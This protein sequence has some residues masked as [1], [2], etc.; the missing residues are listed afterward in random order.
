M[1]QD[2]QHAPL[3]AGGRPGDESKPGDVQASERAD[4]D[5]SG[6]RW[7]PECK[8]VLRLAVPVSLS[9]VVSFVAYLITTAQVGRLGTLELSAITLARSVY[10]ITGMSLVVGMASAVETF[11]GQAYG[12]AHYPV[13]GLVLQRAVTLCLLTCLLPLGLWLRGDW[14]MGQLMGQRP[15]VVPLAAS[16]LRLLGPALVM[17]AVSCCIKNYLS[18]QGVVTPLTV[19]AS[20][21]TLATAALNHVFMFSLGLGMQGAAVAYNLL[22]ALELLLLIGTMAWLHM[23]GQAPGCRT[24]CGFSVQ[25][26]RGWGKY[27]RIALPSGAAICLDWWTYEAVILMAGLLP[28]AKV[29]LGTMGLAFDTH[30][31][32][33]MVVGGFSTAAST[34]VSNELG[35]GRGRW[36][37][38]AALVALGL[39]M[40]APLGISGG[41]LATP[42]QWAALFTKDD[43]IIGL[44]ASLMPVL[45]L[46]NLADSVV[47]VL[48][49]VLRGSGRQELAFKVNLAAFWFL[50]LPL[51][52]RLA[53]HHHLGAL[54]LW[55]AMGLASAL[56]AVILMVS[57]LRFDWAE[58]ARKALR[59]VAATEAG[60][61]QA[62]AEAA[63]AAGPPLPPHVPLHAGMD[64]RHGVHEP[65][66]TLE[67]TI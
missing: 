15:E 59:R 21:C 10:H 65:I 57:V 18:S 60:M 40:A 7:W 28:D 55:M 9:E 63:E 38:F 8:R 17:W 30:A 6:M 42:R 62:A 12:A 24:W 43:T 29:Q 51:A 53:I 1:A 61:R 39:G 34:R 20:I 33:F 52:A 19:V 3:L 44:V 14:V 66:L 56:Q 13:L 31:L 37:R 25:A 35:A 64:S 26:F 4:G 47:S 23:Y 41:L 48:S 50:G 2:E 32:L 16:Y 46:S 58:E 11:C 27:L 45:T 54:G 36:A 67:H 5:T 49:G 22:V